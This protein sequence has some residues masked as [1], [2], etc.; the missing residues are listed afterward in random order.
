VEPPDETLIEHLRG[1]AR[2]ADPVPERML[3]A[4]RSSYSWRTID[5]QL[6]EPMRAN[7]SDLTEAVVPSGHWMAQERPL[8]VN[9]ALA[10]WLA[11]RFPGLWRI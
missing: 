1:L 8:D 6:A 2:C 3:R 7:C 5:S 4:A 10:K 9:A 11:T